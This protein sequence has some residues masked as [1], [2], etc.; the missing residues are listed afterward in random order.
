[1]NYQNFDFSGFFENDFANYALI[2]RAVA[3]GETAG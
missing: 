3:G 1:M 2:R